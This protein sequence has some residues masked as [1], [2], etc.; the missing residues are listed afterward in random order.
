MTGTIGTTGTA[1]TAG[2]TG[3]APQWKRRSAW[4]LGG[5][6]V[7]S[8]VLSGCGQGGAERTVSAY[9]K[10]DDT[11][12]LTYWIAAAEEVNLALVDQFNESKGPEL[13]I[14]VN[15][16]YQG[17]YWEMQQKINASA[18]AGTLPNVFIDEVAMAHGFA[19]SDII[20]N[21]EPFI[22]ATDFDPTD[23]QIGDLGNLRIDGDLYAFPHMRSVP[24]MY[25]NQTLAEQVGLDPAGPATFAELEAYLQA[26]HDATGSPPMYLFNYDFWVMEALLH[27]YSETAVLSEDET[28]SNIN[29]EGAA[30]LVR[31]I[32]ELEGKGLIKVLGLADS[33]AFYATI[34]NPDTALVFS[35]IGGYKPFT[36]MAAEAGV[37]YGVSMIPT[38]EAGTRGV[39]VGGS[40]TYL[41]N[42]GSEREQ[43]AAFEF[44]KWLSD[45]E[46]A[47]YASANT[48]YL[49][50]R[51]SS[52]DTQLM[53][54]TFAAFPGYQVASDQLQHSRMR[55]T[56]GAY[57]E[58]EDV[59]GARL[60][61]IWLDD[62]D[63]QPSLDALAEE[64]N[65]IL[66][67]S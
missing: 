9:E 10:G 35:N 23:F 19:E 12:E 18:I 44:M 45:T 15:A 61:D 17:D 39:P 16:E 43:A 37:E 40:N 66:G 41:A 55:P 14:H 1:G 53:Q 42:T 60:N 5:A 38:G 33:N 28:Q 20:L 26:A 3:I 57:H 67:R 32:A 62:L 63:I 47:A 59:M 49:P 54:E 13:G 11:V 4:L 36:G 25:V 64:V 48:G 7:A 2:T 46:Q 52:L 58:I 30:A 51:L 29:S 22:E 50:T 56:T 27:S 8:A 21:L 24:V 31:F 6:L 65:A 34:S